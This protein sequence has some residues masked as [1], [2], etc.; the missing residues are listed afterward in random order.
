MKISN[1]RL[2]FANNSSSS[3]SIIWWDR[4]E[5]IP[6]GEYVKEFCYGWEAFTLTS[7][8]DKAKYM[9]VMFYYELERYFGSS[10]AIFIIRS[11]FGINLP[12]SEESRANYYQEFFYI[13]HESTVNLPLCYDKPV[14][15]MRFMAELFT[16]ITQTKEIV[17]LGGN[18]NGGNHPIT[19]PNIK[20]WQW[21]V[22]DNHENNRVVARW[23]ESGYWT[24]FNRENGTKFRLSFVGEVPDKS[25]SP[26]LV[27][28]KIT[29]FCP[30][31]CPFCYQSSTISGKHAPLSKINDI[32]YQLGK[33]EVL[34][35]AFGGGEPTLH[36]DFKEI[37]EECRKRNI[38][39]NFTTR[40]YKWLEK[41]FDWVK[42]TCGSVALSVDTESWFKTVGI[43]QKFKKEMPSISMQLVMGTIGRDDYNRF[44]RSCEED[45]KLVLLGFKEVGEGIGFPKTNYS[46]WLDDTKK[47]G[48]LSIGIDTALASEYEGELKRHSINDRLYFTEEGKY[49]MYIDVVDQKMGK[50]SYHQLESFAGID[51]FSDEKILQAYRRW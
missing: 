26:E 4:E 12:N 32:L 42:R 6:S 7:E 3:H 25:H 23:D 30:F 17:I 24:L 19:A 5:A 18:D 13:D 41:N 27:D 9:A 39:P 8:E 36:P 45:D 43:Y 34:E 16:Y 38:V 31:G 2:G 44:L 1:V 21:V 49:S 51:Y 28:L 33:M 50:S 15:N 35:I 48:L 46:W 29:N 40:N 14:T 20:N 37:A 11:M 22:R 10:W 47:S